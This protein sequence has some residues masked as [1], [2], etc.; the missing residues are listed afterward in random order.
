M[1]SR[2]ARKMLQ[3]GKLSM[4]GNTCINAMGDI[5]TKLHGS[6]LLLER[7]VVD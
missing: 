2:W 3:A 6:G 1:D 4:T 7:I 5:Q